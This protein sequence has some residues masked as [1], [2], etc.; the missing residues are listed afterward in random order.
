MV[1]PTVADYI[2][3]KYISK[4]NFGDAARFPKN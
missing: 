2:N 4:T 1:D 3:E